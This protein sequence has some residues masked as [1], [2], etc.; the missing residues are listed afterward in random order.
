[1]RWGRPAEE[2]QSYLAALKLEPSHVRANMSMAI[3]YAEIGQSSLAIHHFRKVIQLAPDS[4]VGRKA[5]ELL[6]SMAH[7]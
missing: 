4:D 5:G 6:S 1:M 3:S 7:K 2:V